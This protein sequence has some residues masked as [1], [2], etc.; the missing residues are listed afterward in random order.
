MCGIAGF[1]ANAPFPDQKASFVLRAMNRI[2]KHRGPDGSGIWLHPEGRAGL[3]HVRLSIIDL[4]PNAAQ[5][6]QAPSGNVLSYNGEI[7][8]FLELREEFGSETFR[9]KSDSEVILRAYEKWGEDCVRHFRGMFAFAL[10]DA[11]IQKLFIAR[12]RF[13]I[14][15][16]YYLIDSGRFY[17]ASEIKALL[18]LTGS[19]EINLEG[20]RDYFT[21]QFSLGIKTLYKG[22][23]QL[24]PAHCGYVDGKLN[25]HLKK[26]WEVR[27]TLDWK[28]DE[29]YFINEVRRRLYDSARLHLRSDVPVG[30]YL[31]GGMDSSL[32]ASIG[33]QL[34]P[35]NVFHAF[36]GKFSGSGDFDESPY[37][38]TLA[39]EKQ[40]SLHEIDMG[41]GD[42]VR[43]ISKV[44]YH[45]DQPVAGPGSFPQYMVSKFARTAL[46]VVL[47]GQ[48]GDEIFGGYVRY[49]IAYFEQCIKGAIDGTMAGGKFIVTYESIIPNLTALQ[50]YKP[51]LQEFWSEGIF[52]SRD[53]RYYRL[54]NR[55]NTFDPMIDWDIFGGS[56][57][58][59]DFKD[60]YWSE[61]VE[62][63]SYFDSMTHF[64]FK[65]LLPALLHVED[66]M[67][68]AHGLESRVPFLDHELVEL[69]ATIPSSIKFQNGELKRLIKTSFRD[70]IPQSIL[71][72]KDKM[73]FPVPL[74]PWMKSKGKAAQFVMDTFRSSKAQNRF[75]L[76]DHFDL[77]SM[78]QAESPFGRNLWALL[79][80]ELWQ[81]QFLDRPQKLT[82]SAD[83]AA[84]EFH[85]SAQTEN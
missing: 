29:N 49:L 24:A 5:P 82:D 67:S 70:E 78:I 2:Q 57:S 8:N 34:R 48:G 17:F 42:F 4:S 43:N 66:R 25:L 51:L 1:I 19:P 26:Y 69:V 9:T 46:K 72:R 37:A 38:R 47:G 60:I 16:F 50:D 30:A 28:H 65:T 58:F 7:Y 55:S 77:D 21:F 62:K 31:S 53:K 64:D 35:E 63:E 84:L 20:L 73:G 36:C 18:P 54:I 76:A 27:Y 22:I 23:H 52:D 85:P 71:E 75:Y 15:P 13:G 74:I 32:V 44:I 3:A 40:I 59:E 79:S 39:R 10:W 80:L 83:D 61:N 12:D 33:R 45:L 81:Q 6:M 41:E 14:K 11:K 68:M 56:S